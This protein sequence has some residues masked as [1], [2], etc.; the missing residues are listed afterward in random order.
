MESALYSFE[1]A[2][3]IIKMILDKGLDHRRS[4]EYYSM[5]VV[6]ICIYARPFTNNY[7]VGKFSQEIVPTEFKYRHILI[8]TLR[9]KLFAHAEAALAAAPDDYP[10]EAVIVNDG[11]RLSL[12]APGRRFGAL[13]LLAERAQRRGLGIPC[14]FLLLPISVAVWCDS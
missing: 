11:E 1:A 7:P 14:Q 9:H 12:A 13:R 6:L 2:R 4:L 5:T 3:D 10:N 8:M